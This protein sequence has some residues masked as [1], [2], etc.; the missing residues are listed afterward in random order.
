[1]S[2]YDDKPPNY[3]PGP[4][5]AISPNSPD[6]C[7]DHDANAPEVVELMSPL[8]ANSVQGLHYGQQRFQDHTSAH[9]T[10]QNTNSE[11][12][13][14]NAT[15][16]EVVPAEYATCQNLES[17][18]APAGNTPSVSPHQPWQ[19]QRAADAPLPPL[20]NKGERILGLKRG[21]FF[22]LLGLLLAVVVAAVVGG[23]AGGVISSK[24]KSSS[25]ANTA[26]TPVPT[27][28]TPTAS[29]TASSASASATPSAT[30]LYNETSFDQGFAFQGFSRNKFSGAYTPIVRDKEGGTDFDFD[31]HSYDWVA[32][33][34][35]CCV[36]FCNNATREGWM[37][38]TCDSR[39]REAAEESFAR[40]FIWCSD[41]HTTPYARG[42]CV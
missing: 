20:P 8:D 6:P 35:N 40:A 2:S 29:S 15:D 38:Y 42:K 4:V 26:S 37:G 1:M 10:H 18:I 3:S 31:I 16:K 32:K 24:S 30:F 39:H 25:D 23:V 33:I 36:S 7:Y 12:N 11:D 21:V 13:G 41:N 34:T 14:G 5:S 22:I 27:P 28:S 9:Y 19:A 17:A